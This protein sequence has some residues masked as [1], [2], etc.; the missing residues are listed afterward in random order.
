MPA[1]IIL[2]ILK[3]K[4]QFSLIPESLPFILKKDKE[5]MKTHSYFTI[6]LILGSEPKELLRS[7]IVSHA[8]SAFTDHYTRLKRSEDEFT[9]TLS[10]VYETTDESRQLVSLRAQEI[11]RKE[12]T[13]T[14]TIN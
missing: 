3:N 2:S 6:S 8:T 12:F 5:P 11:D 13:Y 10:L 9:L 14:S 1:T 7:E 4:T